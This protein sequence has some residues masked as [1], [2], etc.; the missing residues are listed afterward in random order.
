VTDELPTLEASLESLGARGVTRA[1][2]WFDDHWWAYAFAVSFRDAP[3][4]RDGLQDGLADLTKVALTKAAPD[5]DPEFSGGQLV[6]DVAEGT[7]SLE[8]ARAET[9]LTEDRL[10]VDLT[11]ATS[12]FERSPEPEAEHEGEDSTSW[13]LEWH[14]ADAAEDHADW[15]GKFEAVLV[16]DA[17]D[18][19]KA[20]EL[21]GFVESLLD[22]V[23]E[24]EEGEDDEELDPDEAIRGLG[25]AL[26]A[27]GATGA[28]TATVRYV[29][30][31][32]GQALADAMNAMAGEIESERDDP[33]AVVASTYGAVQGLFE[34][35][36]WE[37]VQLEL[38]GRVL[39]DTE[40][41][42]CW[43][44]TAAMLVLLARLGDRAEVWGTGGSSGVLELDL[45][46]T[47]ATL[48]HRHP[49]LRRLPSVRVVIQAHE[50]G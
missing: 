12:L 43:L 6:V 5:Y 8:L 18:P 44:R 19:S 4:S 45:P 20:R 46:A 39:P 1:A 40:P 48:A 37:L 9:E 15:L 17:E 2:T 31:E 24:E 26:A 47:T 11:S 13:D 32:F 25:E 35:S 22:A 50:G 33:A 21:V 34:E 16:E 36:P 10:V 7:I 14:A 23:E 3:R 41:A 29:E 28:T 42:A 49:R 30:E 27:L 38:D